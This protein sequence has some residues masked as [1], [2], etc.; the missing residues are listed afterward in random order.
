LIG[1]DAAERAYAKLGFSV[2][3]EKRHP[4]FEA[5]TGAPGMQRMLAKL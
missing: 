5:A 4:D 3:E 1:N 2:V